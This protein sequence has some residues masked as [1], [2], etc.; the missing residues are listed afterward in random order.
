MNNVANLGVSFGSDIS[1]F[2]QGIRNVQDQLKSV[3]KNLEKAGSELTKNL[4]LPI[5][6]LG[7]VSVKAFSDFEK[8]LNKVATIADLNVKSIDNIKNEVLDLSDVVHIGTGEL[9]EALYQT[10]SATGD[11]VNA[12]DYVKVASKAAVGGFTDVTTSVD[13][14]TTVMNAYGLKGKDAMQKVADQMLMAQNYGKTTFGEMASSMGNVIPIAASLN[15]STKELFASVATL[16]KA[17]I[18]TSEAITGLKAA[19]SNIVKPSEQASKMAK[20]LGINFNSTH[21]KSVGWAN[22]LDEIRQKTNGNVD[23]M[24]QLFGSVE[25]LNAVTVL[26]TTGA[27]DFSG[28]LIAMENSSGSV[29]K[30]FNTMEQGF[31]AQLNALKISLQNLGIMFGEIIVPMI[32]PFVDKLK[33]TITW[34]RGLDTTTQ[35]TIVAVAAIAAAIGPLLIIFSKLTIAASSIKFVLTELGFIFGVSAGTV[36]IIIAAIV[37]LIAI[38]ATLYKTNEGFRNGINAI[39]EG[40]KNVAIIVFDA[41]KNAII[42]AF[43][44]IQEFWNTWGDDITKAFNR[45]WETVKQTWNIYFEIL[46]SYVITIFQGIQE[47]WNKWGA[48]ITRIFKTY[49]EAL[50]VFYTAIFTAIK[51]VIVVIFQAIENFWDKWGDTIVQTFKDYFEILKIIFT[52]VFDIIMKV[53]VNIFNEIEKFWNTWGSTIIAIFNTIFNVI[54]IIFSTVWKAIGNIVD[55]SMTIISNTVK[56]FL[57]I[58]KG[59]WSGAWENIKNIFVA[60]KDLIIANANLF[61]D[62]LIS[63][64]NE[65]KDKV[66]GLAIALKDGIVNGLKKL[67]LEDIPYWIGFAIGKMISITDSGIKNTVKFF[68]ELPGKIMEFLKSLPSTIANL[69]QQT[70]NDTENV[71]KDF[72]T[73]M[74]GIFVRAKDVITDKIKEI[75]NVI[76]GVIDKIHDA[77]DAIKNFNF[78]KVATKTVKVVQEV[79]QKVTG[80]INS[81]MQAGLEQHAAGGIFTKPTLWGNHL[82]GEAGAEALIPLDRLDNMVG[83]GGQQTINVYLDGQRIQATIDNKMGK[84]LAL[85]GD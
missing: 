5:L 20:Q 29:D 82:I 34:L 43:N 42:F 85:G 28:A 57:N 53:V 39:W 77:L 11:T 70:K 66:I 64:W 1:G 74:F 24:S 35:T 68:S 50:K 84:T 56:L 76:T 60:V 3:S 22:F 32:Q 51:N 18:G 45:V 59:D 25:A 71:M 48:D 23:A 6:G 72:P 46:K 52:T 54:K 67:F 19:Y 78:A 27:E 83:T 55:T 79:T 61:K 69:F 36:G 81:G 80:S 2:Q 13:G 31:S 9:N 37:A 47:F 63:I 58:L 33:E 41:I 15:I 14:L 65:V 21:L 75:K 8:G 4:T 40:I 44:G 12:L 30:A 38:F 7:A 26:A 10:I 16:T 49:I 73:V 62:M 17:G